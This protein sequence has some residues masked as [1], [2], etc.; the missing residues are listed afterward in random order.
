MKYKIQVSKP[1]C[2]CILPKYVI[3]HLIAKTLVNDKPEYL[4]KGFSQN[5]E[6]CR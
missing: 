2:H 3:A 4:F 5:N 6:P 1:I